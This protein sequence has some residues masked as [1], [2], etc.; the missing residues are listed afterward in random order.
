MFSALF[1]AAYDAWPAPLI[2][3]TLPRV[4]EMLTT[5]RLSPRSMSGRNACVTYTGPSAFARKTRADASMSKSVAVSWISWLGG[6]EC[7][8]VS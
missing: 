6:W 3:V 7:A 5:V 2:E 8:H 4:L 1:A